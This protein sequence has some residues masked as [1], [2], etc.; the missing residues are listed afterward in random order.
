MGL[1]DSNGN[2]I[3]TRDMAADI[4]MAREPTDA[5]LFDRFNDLLDEYFTVR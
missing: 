5:R 2:V 4:G 1:Y 3:R